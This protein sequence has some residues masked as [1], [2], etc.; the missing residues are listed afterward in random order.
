MP[1]GHIEQFA[2]AL[3][4]E[5]VRRGVAGL[6]KVAGS[7]GSGVIEQQWLKAVAD[8][9]VNSQGRS[10]IV[11]G[12]GQPVRVHALVHA[13]NEA[14]KSAGVTVVYAPAIDVKDEASRDSIRQLVS[15]AAN[16]TTLIML[17]GNPAYAAPADLK[18]AELLDMKGLTSVHFS[19]HRDETTS[20]C[21]WHMP[22]IHELEAWGDQR[23][24]SGVVSVQQPLIAPLYGARSEIEI[25]AMLAG[26]KKTRGHDIVRETFQASLEP[27]A[28]R[29][30]L[31]GEMREAF[32]SKSQWNGS[33]HDGMMFTSFLQ[34]RFRNGFLR[35]EARKVDMDAVAKALEEAPKRNPIGKDNIE[36]SFEPDFA[37]H[38]GRHAN[39][40]WALELPRPM[41]KLVWD[42]AALMSPST[43]DALG[44]KNG[45]MIRLSKGDAK[46]EVPVWTVPGHADF[47][48]TLTLGWGRTAAGRYGNGKGFDVYPLRTSDAMD[49]TDGVSVEPLREM[50]N[51]VQ[52]QSHDQ[53]EGRPIAIDATLDEYKKEPDFATSGEW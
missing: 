47:C 6:E 12:S 35:L 49:F 33:L 43:R 40:L 28:D 32:R 53:M 45:Q 1:R 5:L 31:S 44:L 41:T 7:I 23:S 9:L 46:V 13:M 22:L 4:A 15:D 3:A 27:V 26:E 8:D 16:T 14:L 30:S 21:S 10:I 11:A 36:V 52:T 20:R 39:N 18:F 51:L 42:N 48:I 17:G 37:L 34:P 24:L 29:L 38:D 50:Y 19:T 2:R 25:L